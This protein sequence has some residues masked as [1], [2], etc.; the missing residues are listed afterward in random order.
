MSSGWTPI[1]VPLTTNS[2]AN[3]KATVKTTTKPVKTTVKIT[4]KPKLKMPPKAAPTAAEGSSN[5]KAGK[6]E[7]VVDDELKLSKF[8]PISRQHSNPTRYSNG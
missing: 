4:L 5:P 7:K 3:V 2:N 1:N 8:F 6:T